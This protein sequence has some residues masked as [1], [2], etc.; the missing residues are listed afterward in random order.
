MCRIGMC[1]ISSLQL[2]RNEIHL[3]HQYPLH[4]AIFMDL[5]SQ[6]AGLHTEIKEINSFC[7]PLDLRAAVQELVH[8]KQVILVD[9]QN[10]EKLLRIPCPEVQ[11]FEKVLHLFVLHA[12]LEL[13]VAYRAIVIHIHVP[14]ELGQYV[15]E[16]MLVDHQRLHSHL[17]VLLCTLDRRIAEDTCHHVE[18]GEQTESHVRAEEVDPAPADPLKRIRGLDP[19]QTTSDGHEQS[20]DGQLQVSK[21]PCQ[22]R[23]LLRQKGVRRGDQRTIYSL[24]ESCGEHVNQQ[25]QKQHRPKQVSKSHEDGMEKGLE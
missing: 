3:G 6:L 24:C 13:R 4:H 21:E 20:V 25:S 18:D 10:L 11:G 12:L 8:P 17:L 22:C 5:L 16:L 14:E 2:R 19:R 15:L 7:I 9:I 23:G 1:G